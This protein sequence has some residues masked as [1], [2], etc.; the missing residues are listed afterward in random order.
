MKR[1]LWLLGSLIPLWIFAAP[2]LADVTIRYQSAVKVS[3]SLPA[4]AREQMEK[5]MGRAMTLETRLKNGKA[6]TVGGFWTAM[7]DFAKGQM[8]LID[9][10]NQTFA[11]VAAAD[12]PDK[13]GALMPQMPDAAK[14]MLAAMKTGFNS[15]KTD[16]TDTIQGI[17]AEENEMVLTIEMPLPADAKQA[18]LTMKM[19]MQI[20]T[21][22]PDEALR[23][24]AVRELMGVNLWSNA[25]MNPGVMMQRMTGSMP[26]LG[27]ALKSMTEQ[28]AVKKAVMLRN[29]MSMYMPVPGVTGDASTPTFEMT[30][31]AVEV[32]SAPVDDAVFQIPAGYKEIPADDLLKAVM[33][34]QQAAVGVP[35]PKQ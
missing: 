30:Q 21:A 11:N 3:Q 34:R 35:N 32:S 33:Q 28:L 6:Y 9:A 5:S 2:L 10:G 16:R 7:V 19:V 14:K 25:F 13:L 4:Q 29:R 22:K 24:P 17:K 15:R 20:W 18:F 12:L 8:T 27:D 31:E 26:G 1:V 23:N